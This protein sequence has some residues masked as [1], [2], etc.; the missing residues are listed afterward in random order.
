MLPF[1]HFRSRVVLGMSTFNNTPEMIKNHWCVSCAP[2]MLTGTSKL[3]LILSLTVISF[4]TVYTMAHFPFLTEDK[5]GVGK[6][7]RQW[8][9]AVFTNWII[10]IKSVVGMA[11]WRQVQILAKEGNSHSG[12]GPGLGFPLSLPH[13]WIS[14]SSH[15][16]M[17]DPDRWLCFNI[18]EINDPHSRNDEPFH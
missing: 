15:L 11:G 13:W 10:S 7:K 14:P 6:I 1:S 12:G 4:L 16:S 18:F 2:G 3:V 5:S 9:F 17:R 8:C